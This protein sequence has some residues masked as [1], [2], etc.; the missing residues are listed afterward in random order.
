MRDVKEN[1]KK[2]MR[3]HIPERD[4]RFVRYI[5]I[6]AQTPLEWIVGGERGTACCV[7]QRI[8]VLVRMGTPRTG[9][10]LGEGLSPLGIDP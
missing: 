5:L 1:L 3:Y 2:E 7:A 9:L 4:Q 10:P 6:S 8:T